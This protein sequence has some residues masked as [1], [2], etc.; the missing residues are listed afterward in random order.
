MKFYVTFGQR[1]AREEHPSFPEAHPD[2]WVEVIADTEYA[3]RVLTKKRL[4]TAWS[5]MYTEKIWKKYEE[6]ENS[7]ARFPRGSLGT[8]RDNVTTQ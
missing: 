1:Y 3:A 4:G 2:G 5:H 6:N 8:F 7:F